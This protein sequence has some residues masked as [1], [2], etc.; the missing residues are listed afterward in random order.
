[1]GANCVAPRACHPNPI[2]HSSARGF[3]LGRANHKK[4]YNENYEFVWRNLTRRE[5][6]RGKTKSVEAREKKQKFVLENQANGA[7]NNDPI[8]CIKFMFIWLLCYLPLC[9]LSPL[10]LRRIFQY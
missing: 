10:V 8:L 3:R 9:S 6:R 7:A 4:K 1:M 2:T 5:E